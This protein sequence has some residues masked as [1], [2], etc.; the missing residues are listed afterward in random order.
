MLWLS[1]PPPSGSSCG[2]LLHTT[3]LRDGVGLWEGKVLRFP[4]LLSQEE[5]RAVPLGPVPTPSQEE[6]RETGSFWGL[7]NGKDIHGGGRLGW[8]SQGTLSP[9]VPPFSFPQ[10]SLGRGLGAPAALAPLGLL[11]GDW[12]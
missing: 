10:G 1:L 9:Q 8:V 11:R 2:N 4:V 6:L 3:A 5:S 7:P 12:H